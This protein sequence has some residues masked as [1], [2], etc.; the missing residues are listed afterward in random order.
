M[1]K[2]VI[3]TG[4]EV[5]GCTYHMKE[6]FIR[7]LEGALEIVEFTLPKDMP[8][9]CC[10]CKI[11]FVDSED[12]CPHA[13]TV[14]TIW[15][16]MRDAD[17]IVFAEPVYAMHSPGQVKALLD[18]LCCH[19]MVHRPEPAM[20]TKH[21]AI[22]TQSIGAPNGSAQKDI[23][24][25]LSWMGVPSIRRLGFGLM[26]GV[27]WD[28]LSE[29]RR[30]K[31]ETKIMRFASRFVDKKPARKTLK[32]RILFFITRQIHKGLLQNEATPSADN[33]HWIDHGWIKEKK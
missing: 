13:K 20:F 22:L 10:G 14:M 27:I 23:A 31:I 19:W 33:K 25:S 24:T 16:A 1:K 18:H 4:T 26:E 17:L 8:H 28:E 29:K 9:F 7:G 15:N 3:I 30:H 12:H 32:T 21:A 11:C 6:A 2:A 5:K